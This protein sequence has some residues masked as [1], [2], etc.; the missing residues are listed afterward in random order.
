MENKGKV[1]QGSLNKELTDMPDHSNA[2]T[3]ATE[4][5]LGP[6]LFDREPEVSNELIDRGPHELDNG[7]IFHG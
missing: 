4:A 1:L 3:R 7:A 2:A 5:R 6:F